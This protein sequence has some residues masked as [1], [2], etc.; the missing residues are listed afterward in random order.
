MKLDSLGAQHSIQKPMCASS[1]SITKSS[2]STCKVKHHRSA[3]VRNQDAVTSKCR[4]CAYRAT[5]DSTMCLTRTEAPVNGF[6]PPCLYMASLLAGPDLQKKRKHV[7]LQ[8][9]TVIKG[10]HPEYNFK[11]MLWNSKKKTTYQKTLQN[12]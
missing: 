1:V 10:Q 11:K 6:P 8:F 4:A 5:R 12:N 2:C 3:A 7:D 9:I